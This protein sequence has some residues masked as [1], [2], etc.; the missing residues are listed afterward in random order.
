MSQAE[1]ELKRVE[2]TSDKRYGV[3]IEEAPSAALR[4][5]R[6]PGEDQGRRFI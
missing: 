1:S 5:K 6:A 2:R 4:S 3:G